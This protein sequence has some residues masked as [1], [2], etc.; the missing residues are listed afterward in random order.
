MD[1]EC[2]RCRDSNPEIARFCARC[3]L[4]LEAGVDGP[5]RPGRV[6]HPRP[7][8]VPRGYAACED[9]VDLYFRSES[10][11]GGETLIGT[12]GV[13]IV[14]FNAG[15]P[16]RE[17]ELGARGEGKDGCELFAVTH[18]L[19]QLGQAKEVAIEIP[20]YELPASLHLLRVRLISAEFGQ[21][22]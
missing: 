8:T 22:A 21:D 1:L 13:N 16:L 15:Y 11:L 19:E 9:A 5:R 12:E 3:G 6:R 17:I 18:A 2:P 4:S 20:S 7:A 10:S 14:L